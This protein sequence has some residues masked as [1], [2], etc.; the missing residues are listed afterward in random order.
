MEFNNYTPGYNNKVDD[1]II[2]SKY[3]LTEEKQLVRL[4]IIKIKIK[5]RIEMGWST[6][7]RQYN[8]IKSSVRFTEE[9][10]I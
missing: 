8:V 2:V 5:R 1:K 3:K 6:S 10:S 9:K 4:Q 7:G